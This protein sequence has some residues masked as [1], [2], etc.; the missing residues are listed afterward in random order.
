MCA[1]CLGSCPRACREDRSDGARAL[2]LRPARS[3]APVGPPAGAHACEWLRRRTCHRC[4]PVA[5]SRAAAG[6]GSGGTQGDAVSCAGRGAAQHVCPARPD[7]SF[8]VR[9]PCAA[10]SSPPHR[11]PK[12][13]SAR[14]PSSPAAGRGRGGA[15]ERPSCCTPA[16][17]HMLCVASDGRRGAAR[18]SASPDATASAC[19]AAEKTHRQP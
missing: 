14:D 6:V 17:A 10:A 12:K 11:T 8:R 7:R 4:S 3:C 19:A 15:R 5:E 9:V 1:T 13:Q 16:H 2:P 18:A